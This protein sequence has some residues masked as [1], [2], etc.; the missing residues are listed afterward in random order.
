MPL[1]L[2][3]TVRV[4]P[5]SICFAV[6]PTPGTNPPLASCTTPDMVA[7]NSCPNTRPFPDTINAIIPAT[8]ATAQ[9]PLPLW[10]TMI[11]AFLSVPTDET[12][13]RSQ[14]GFRL[15]QRDTTSVSRIDSV[16]IAW[17]YKAAKCVCISGAGGIA[18]TNSGEGRSALRRSEVNELKRH[19]LPLGEG[20]AK[21]KRDSAR[22]KRRAKPQEKVR[23]SRF[24][25]H[26]DWSQPV[27]YLN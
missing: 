1:S 3:I 22:L 6:T 24:D 17:V 8:K 26:R 18:G 12:E 4:S 10:L 14:R 16:S 5:L 15:A 7:E 13:H 27:A 9:R 21:R 23:V 20:G 25:R 2:V 19:P 11:S